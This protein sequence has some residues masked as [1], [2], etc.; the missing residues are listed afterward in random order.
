M[1]LKPDLND[2]FP[3]S[4]LSAFAIFCSINTPIVASDDFTEGEVRRLGLVSW[5]SVS[6]CTTWIFTPPSYSPQTLVGEAGGDLID[7]PLGRPAVLPRPQ[8]PELPPMG[9]NTNSQLAISANFL[10]SVLTMLQKQGALDIDITDGMVSQPSRAVSCWS[11]VFPSLYLRG[12]IADG[13]VLYPVLQLGVPV[14]QRW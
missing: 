12:R 1:S 14:H 3:K 10:G 13:P 9:D 2:F 8:M 6:I 11:R 7:Y 4:W 5:V